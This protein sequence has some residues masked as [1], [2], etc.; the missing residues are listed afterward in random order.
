MGVSDGSRVVNVNETKEN[1]RSEVFEVKTFSTFQRFR[2]SVVFGV[3]T[4]DY[5][6]F[7]ELIRRYFLD[8]AKFDKVTHSHYNTSVTLEIT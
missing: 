4:F 7:N 1:G 3:L 2:G 8:E 6:I 5:I